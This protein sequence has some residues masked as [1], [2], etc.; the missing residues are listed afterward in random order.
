MLNSL[1]HVRQ[2]LAQQNIP[3]VLRQGDAEEK[4]GQF[5]REI[6]AGV[7]VFDFSPLTYARSLVESIADNFDGSVLEVDAHNIVP[8]WVASDKQEF[9]AHTFRRKIHRQLEA[10]LT[11]PDQVQPHPHAARDVESLSFAEAKQS[12]TSLPSCG[13]QVDATPGEP[14]A[15]QLLNDFVDE[16]LSHYALR[17]NDF[18]HDYQTGLSPYLHFGQIASLRVALNILT[19]VDEPPLL[20]Q[21]AKMAET[22]NTPSR[23]DG[24]NALL[25]ELIV[26]KELSDNFCFYNSDYTS[27]DGAPDWARKTLD[28]HRGDARDF[29]YSLNQ[30]ETAKTHD[31]AWNAAQKQL[32]KTGKL[33]GYLRM[34]WAKKLLEWSASPE[35]ALSTANYLNDKYSIDGGDP[36]GYVGVLWAI[37]G[38]HDRPW[39][40]RSVYGTI[41]YMNSGGLQRKS[42][43]AAYIRTW[44]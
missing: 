29:L 4:I 23:S 16:K 26:R 34:Y 35:E 1:E 28:K 12:I 10:Y 37:A 14:A 41:R 33:H 5:C 40:E 30:W 18:A 21:R 13:I 11:E 22:G 27:L 19:A 32:T 20:L 24:M 38:L 31:D 9:A 17:R 6:K 3:F 36:N 39:F 44:R 25:E 8:V 2:G 43:L 15:D 42:D 7:V